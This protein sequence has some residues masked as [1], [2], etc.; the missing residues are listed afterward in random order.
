MCERHM[1]KTKNFGFKFYE[2][3][4]E[5]KIF[6]LML[7]VFIF[8]FLLGYWCKNIEY[9]EKIYKQKIEIIDLKE[10]VDRAIYENRKGTSNNGR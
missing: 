3:E 8:S 6:V 1:K 9:E 4:Q 7:I 10:Q 5:L 2:I